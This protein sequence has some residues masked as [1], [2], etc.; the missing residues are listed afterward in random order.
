MALS[1]LDDKSKVPDVKEL[2][3]VLGRSHEHWES[4]ITFLKSE[5]EPLDQM[6][7]FGGKNWGWSL[8]LKQKK[9]T[10][11]YMTPCEGNILV[12]F[13][14][15]EKAVKAAHESALPKSVLTVIDKAKKYAEGRGV[16]IEVGN[17]KDCEVV[18]KLAA[19][20][21]NN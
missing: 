20:K 5:Y 18:K 21:M 6:W 3:R 8:R 15:G 10:V 2:K 13:V 7:N 17:K 12:G 1:A 14:L 16:R 4:L 19:I 11:L 9:R